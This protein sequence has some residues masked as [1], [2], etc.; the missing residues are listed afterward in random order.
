MPIRRN[1]RG[2]FTAIRDSQ[3]AIT[4]SSN[5]R[6][7]MNEPLKPAGSPQHQRRL[8]TT[9]NVPYMLQGEEGNLQWKDGGFA[10]NAVGSASIAATTLVMF[11]HIVQNNGTITEGNLQTIQ[12]LVAFIPESKNDAF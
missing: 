10:E 11:R 9:E 12:E 1:S 2:R 5:R 4:P 7:A 3:K 6:Q 8:A